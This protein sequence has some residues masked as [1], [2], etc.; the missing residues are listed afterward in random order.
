M[1]LR[2]YRVWLDICK[3]PELQMKL[4][5]SLEELEWKEY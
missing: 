4:I 2:R 3:I 1:K 5:D